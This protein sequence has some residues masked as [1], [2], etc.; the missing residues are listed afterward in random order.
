[1]QTFKTYTVSTLT[2]EPLERK[3]LSF[4]NSKVSRREP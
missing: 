3:M 2:Y 4:G 1:M